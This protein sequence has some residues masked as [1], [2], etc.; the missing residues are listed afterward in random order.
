MSTRRQ[1]LSLE[2]ATG[3]GAAVLVLVLVT[4]AEFVDG[5]DAAGS[6]WFAIAPF[7]AAAF[8]PWRYVVGIGGLAI[9]ITTALGLMSDDGLDHVTAVRLLGLAAA[10][11]GAIAVSVVRQ[12]QNQRYADLVRLA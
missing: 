3:L 2:A 9:A 8:T 12:N 5:L 6:G 1:K 7:L 11:A 4:G 10:T